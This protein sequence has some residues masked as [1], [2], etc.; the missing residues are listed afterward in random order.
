MRPVSCTFCKIFLILCLSS[1]IA[2]GADRVVIGPWAAVEGSTNVAWLNGGIQQT[3]LADLS[4]PGQT[5][6]VAIKPGTSNILETARQQDGRWLISGTYQV[7]ASQV[8][9]TGQVIDLSTGQA[10]GGLKATGNERD[11]FPLQDELSRQAQNVIRKAIAP[12]VNQQPTT[13]PAMSDLVPTGPIRIVVEQQPA[14][15]DRVSFDGSSLQRAVDAG[16]IDPR[17]I[18][19]V[20]NEAIYQ[21][22]Y[23]GYFRSPVLIGGY[24]PSWYGNCFSGYPGYYWSGYRHTDIHISRGSRH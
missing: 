13:A 6:A 15:A 23:T 2:G 22:G 21:Y 1:T 16:Q 17:R 8:R 11:I 19:R 14:N 12:L 24:T 3:L 10:I 4:R 18:N 20:R 9:L 5:D 7:A